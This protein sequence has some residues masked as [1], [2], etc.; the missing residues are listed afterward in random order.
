MRV[1]HQIGQKV[2]NS[3]GLSVPGRENGYCLGAAT[4]AYYAQRDEADR[5]AS[6]NMR[7][8]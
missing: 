8:T 1:S 6:S 4:C 3:E 7:T 5:V 2:R